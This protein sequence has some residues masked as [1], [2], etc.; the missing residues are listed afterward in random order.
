MAPPRRCDLVADRRASTGKR[1]DDD[2]VTVLVLL[3]EAGKDP[4]GVPPVA[5][6]TIRHAGAD[7]RSRSGQFAHCLT[8]EPRHLKPRERV[9]AHRPRALRMPS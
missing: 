1:Q 8:V 9:V 4:A 7:T 2:I 6:Q 5:K 3:E